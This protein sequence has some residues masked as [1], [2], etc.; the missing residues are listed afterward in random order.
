MKSPLKF[1]DFESV[2]VVLRNESE[3]T[4][5]GSA[6]VPPHL[7]CRRDARVP[8]YSKMDKLFKTRS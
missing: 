5:L 3:I 8:G 7:Y 4:Q 2:A 6:G 1:E